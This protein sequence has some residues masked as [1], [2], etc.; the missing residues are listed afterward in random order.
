MNDDDITKCEFFFDNY[1][2]SYKFMKKFSDNKIFYNRNYKWE[3][4]KYQTIEL[5]SPDP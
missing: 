5:Q 2:T 1:F 3:L 4:N